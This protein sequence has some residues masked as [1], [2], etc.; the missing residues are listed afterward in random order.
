VPELRDTRLIAVS[1]YGQP[2]DRERTRAAGFDEHL[3]KPVSSRSVSR[4]IAGIP[5]HRPAPMSSHGF[6]AG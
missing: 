4:A 1:G 5:A 2:R 6:S 3:I